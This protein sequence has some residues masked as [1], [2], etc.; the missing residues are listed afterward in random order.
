MWVVLFFLP[1]SFG[2]V[3]S[4]LHS[5]LRSSGCLWSYIRIHIDVDDVKLRVNDICGNQTLVQSWQT[6]Q[7]C[8]DEACA[9]A[10]MIYPDLC[11]C[12]FKK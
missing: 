1:P 2:L 3:S 12:V 8:Y 5:P 9:P 11:L 7:R 10:E 4:R 6:S